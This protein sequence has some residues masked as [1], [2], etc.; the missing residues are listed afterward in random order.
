MNTTKQDINKLLGLLC[1][2]ASVTYFRVIGQWRMEVIDPLRNK[3]V[4]CKEMNEWPF[5]LQTFRDIPVKNSSGSS[6]WE[7][8]TGVRPSDIRCDFIC[9]SE[10][11]RDGHEASFKPFVCGNIKVKILVQNKNCWS[12]CSKNKIYAC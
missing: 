11:K 2:Y 3:T 8:R 6:S 4:D 10:Y 1:A 5:G 7:E 9:G 12:R